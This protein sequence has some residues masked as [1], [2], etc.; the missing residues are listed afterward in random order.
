M[1]VMYRDAEIYQTETDW[2]KICFLEIVKEPEM[3]VNHYITFYMYNPILHISLKHVCKID[4]YIF[5]VIQ[6]THH[7]CTH[8]RNFVAKPSVSIIAPNLCPALLKYLKYH[9]HL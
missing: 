7:R 4:R 6:N 8:E 3:K 1:K 2:R 9:I 5:I